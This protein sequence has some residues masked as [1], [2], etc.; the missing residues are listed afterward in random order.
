MSRAP[1]SLAVLFYF[2]LYFITD[3]FTHESTDDAFLDATSV[4]VAPRVA[5]QIRKLAVVDNQAVKAGDLIAEIDPR[6]FAVQVA[7]KKTAGVA[8][9]ANV[10][11]LLSSIEFLGTQV[12]TAEATAN[13]SEAQ[14]SANEA[15]RPRGPTPI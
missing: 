11:L 12:A 7:Q 9:E 6:D 10:K 8:A 15:L 4:S 2:R 14:A 5:G 3:S 13:Q 1:S